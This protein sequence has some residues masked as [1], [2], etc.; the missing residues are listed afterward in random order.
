[1]AIRI[2][3]IANFR[4]SIHASSTV[5]WSFSLKRPMKFMAIGSRKNTWIEVI[6]SRSP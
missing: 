4:R 1:M 6:A 5:G 2:E 3:R